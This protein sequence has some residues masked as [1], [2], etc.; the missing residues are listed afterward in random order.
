VRSFPDRAV[1]VQVLAGDIALCFWAWHS[2]I[3][4]HVSTQVY[5]WNTGEFKAGGNPAMD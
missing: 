5:K 1:R 3:I 2:I 4:V